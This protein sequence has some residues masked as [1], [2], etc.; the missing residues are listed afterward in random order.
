MNLATPQKYDVTATRALADYGRKMAAE[1]YDGF[2]ALAA[3]GYHELG[4]AHQF[5]YAISTVH[6]GLETHALPRYAE[7]PTTPTATVTDVSFDQSAT[8]PDT[9]VTGASLQESVGRPS[10][11]VSGA[12]LEQSSTV[13]TA[14]VTDATFQQLTALPATTVADAT[15]QASIGPPTTEVSDAVV[16]HHQITPSEPEAVSSGITTDDDPRLWNAK[17]MSANMSTF[18]QEASMIGKSLSETIVD[19]GAQGRDE[20]VAKIE[21]PLE[22][23][24]GHEAQPDMGV[25]V[26]MEMEPEPEPEPEM[27]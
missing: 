12:T 10:I 24:Q 20:I 27:D 13:P 15:L 9:V 4:T 14:S 1:L 16:Q 25:E 23:F 21:N 22:G 5:G 11:K 2:E 17:K 26:E 3:Q 18:S 6:Y 7:I 8:I 19:K